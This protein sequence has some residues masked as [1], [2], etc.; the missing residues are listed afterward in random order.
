M[1]RELPAAG[2]LNTI[3]IE[4]L[5][6]DAD[7]HWFEVAGLSDCVVVHRGAAVDVLATLQGPPTTSPSSMP[8]RRTTRTTR[9]SRWTSAARRDSMTGSTVQPDLQLLGDFDRRRPIRATSLHDGNVSR[10]AAAVR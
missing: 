3:E 6:A 5:H 2:R 1:A 8:T 7:E 4:P 10:R 9:V